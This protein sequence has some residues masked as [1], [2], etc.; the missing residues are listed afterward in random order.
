MAEEDSKT[1]IE[2]CED[3]E[4]GDEEPHLTWVEKYD[5]PMPQV[6]KILFVHILYYSYL[7]NHEALRT[8]RMSSLQVTFCFHSIIISVRSP[9]NNHLSYYIFS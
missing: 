9:L 3:D 6:K 1:E 2:N 4:S 8:S 5:R 7:G